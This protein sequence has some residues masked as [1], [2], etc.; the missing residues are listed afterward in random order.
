MFEN[1]V[2]RK[3]SRLHDVIVKQRVRGKAERVRVK[4]KGGGLEVIC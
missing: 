2:K 3:R 1:G 4:V